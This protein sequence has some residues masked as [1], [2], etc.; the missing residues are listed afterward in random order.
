MTSGLI[1]GGRLF[2]WM[3]SRN[4]RDDSVVASIVGVVGMRMALSVVIAMNV[5]MDM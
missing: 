2:E 3:D 1:G 5:V 4:G